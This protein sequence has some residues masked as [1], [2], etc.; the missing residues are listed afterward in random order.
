MT[1]DELEAAIAELYERSLANLD[2]DLID[3]GFGP[4]TRE[5]MQRFA[6]DQM[7]KECEKQLANV[8]ALIT[9]EG[10]SLN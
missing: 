3:A 6:R 10:E 4:E 1:V 9:R 7:D 5:E 8:K 2:I